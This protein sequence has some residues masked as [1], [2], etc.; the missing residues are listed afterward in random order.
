MAV[1]N[2]EGSAIDFPGLPGIFDKKYAKT[3]QGWLGTVGGITTGAIVLP[4]SGVMAEA[5][6]TVAITSRVT[7]NNLLAIGTRGQAG[8][9]KRFGGVD[10][11]I[12][13]VLTNNVNVSG[14]YGYQLSDFDNIL[15]SGFTLYTTNGV[16][17]KS[18]SISGLYVNSVAFTFNQNAD[19]TMA[20]TFVGNGVVYSGYTVATQGSQGYSDYHCVSPL[21]WDEIHIYDTKDGVVLTGVQSATFNAT[22]NRSDIFQIGQFT[23]YD[24]AVV[25]PYNVTVSLNTLAN[26]VRLVGFW[27]KFVPTYDPMSDCANGFIIKVRT[28]S[29]ANDGT[30]YDLIIASGL[31]PT[32]STLNAAVG[33]NSTVVL[34]FDGTRLFF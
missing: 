8:W 22:I 14:A 4:Y 19:S 6:Q 1:S 5:I 20:M 10:L 25:Y 30:A 9:S 17:G 21:T 13:A 32:T 15:A 27:E 28:S 2:H 33:S 26:D 11:S 23:P 34:A 29:N 18:A 24:R 7:A 31:K 3:T 12:D 16:L